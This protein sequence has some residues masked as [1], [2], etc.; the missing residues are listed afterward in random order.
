MTKAYE[1]LQT[2]DHN[3]QEVA[4]QCGFSK[5]DSFYKAFKRTYGFPPSDILNRRMV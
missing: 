2:G 3:I 1:M 5:A 4:A